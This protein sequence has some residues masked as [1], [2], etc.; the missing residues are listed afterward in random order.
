MPLQHE[1]APDRIGDLMLCEESKD[2]LIKPLLIGVEFRFHGRS[3]RQGS[4]LQSRSGGLHVMR[5]R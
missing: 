3:H 4:S 2:V 1:S 5:P